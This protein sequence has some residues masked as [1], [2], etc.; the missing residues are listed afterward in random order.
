MANWW[1]AGEVVDASAKKNWWEEGQEVQTASE[2]RA[3]RTP[4]QS[5]AQYAGVINE[6]L[7]PYALAA[8]G[9]AA[10]GGPAGA[11]MAP[12]ALGL[13]D[14]AAAGFN[15]G[16]G[17][18]G[19]EARAP[20]PSDIIRGGAR[21]VAPSAF[22]TPQT[23]PEQ[24]LGTAAE[25]LTSTGTQINAIRKLAAQADPGAFRNVLSELGAQPKVQAGAAVPAAL[26]PDVLQNLTNEGALLENPDTYAVASTIASFLAG[27]AGGAA[28]GKITGAGGVKVPPTKVLRQQADQAYKDVDQMGVTF[29]P[30]AYDQFLADV[31]NRLDG[32]DPAQHGAV[33]LEIKNLEKSL[34]QA[35]TV[36]ELDTAR[37]NIR[38]KLGKS[39]DANVRRLGQEL[40]DEL[41]TFVMSSPPTSI[42]SGNYSEATAT[43]QRGR[44]MYAAV[45]K[46]EAMEDLLERARLSDEPLDKA[47]R[48]EFRLLA[49]NRRA[50]R[51]YSPE[52][53]QFIK[54]VVRGGDV[55][56]WLTNLSEALRVRSGLGGGLYA[57]TTIGVFTPQVTPGMAVAA[58]T[59]IGSL[60]FGT[61]K[62][63]ETLATRRAQEAA[64]RMRGGQRPRF[65]A[66]PVA[67]G[68]AA[69][70][71]ALS[72]GE[73]N[74]LAQEQQR[75]EIEQRRNMLGF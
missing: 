70:M 9:G 17:A 16:A 69:G 61:R 32:F 60:Q 49:K 12:L 58:A 52:E 63:A 72:P 44:Q 34:G 29:T 68:L 47:I 54:D 6:R 39:T 59:G 56:R 43:L 8:A 40:A 14:L 22:R 11:A 28:T 23:M 19:A 21:R 15:V 75:A 13:T 31:R 67:G 41:D 37:S 46:S 57:G 10:V 48:N 5:V 27:A 1:E 38:K 74:F 42:A 25:A 66:L 45:S 55:A 30:Q 26:A 18:L 3:Q 65:Q 24:Y 71:N 53:R 50:F 7:A 4:A 73:V 20:Y 62:A 33:E 35:R 64:L 51:L 36:S 2:I